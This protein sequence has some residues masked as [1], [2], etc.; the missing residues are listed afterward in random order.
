MT[1][2][3]VTGL[4]VLAAFMIVPRV[5]SAATDTFMFVPGIPGGSVDDKHKDWIDVVSLQ[6]SWPGTV[7]KHTSCDVTVVKALDIAGPKLWLAAVTGQLFAEI[8]IE[9]VKEGGDPFKFYELKLIN[10]QISSITTNGTGP[11]F[12]E[13]VVLSPQSATLSFFQQNRD[14]STGSPVTVTVPCN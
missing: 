13:D 1:K 4:F 5:A 3:M 14:G 10:A 6:Q 7:R 2:R 9:V 11:S 12:V 8:K